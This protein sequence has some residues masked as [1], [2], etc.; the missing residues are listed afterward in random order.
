MRIIKAPEV[1]VLLCQ[2]CQLI[3]YQVLE[4]K[5]M[6]QSMRVIQLGD[7]NYE[8]INMNYYSKPQQLY[9]C[10][11]K[12]LLYKI[13]D[14][15]SNAS[16]QALSE[17][18][19]V[20][21]SI[22]LHYTETGVAPVQCRIMNEDMCVFNQGKAVYFVKFYQE[23]Q[24]TVVLKCAFNAGGIAHYVYKHNKGELFASEQGQMIQLKLRQQ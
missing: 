19:Y 24:N 3:V 9:L 13:D 12:N 8:F 20:R 18:D 17:S 7:K 10:S 14:Y 21:Q 23:S 1:V 11:K 15:R 5:V 6:A 16:L 4:G 22:W 2:N